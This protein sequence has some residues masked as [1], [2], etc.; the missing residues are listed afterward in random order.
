MNCI[1]WTAVSSLHSNRDEQI[2]IVPHTDPYDSLSRNI[3]ECKFGASEYILNSILG[4]KNQNNQ[5]QTKP[6]GIPKHVLIYSLI[7]KKN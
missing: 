4:K 3:T 5:N 7:K 2:Q 1:L 6:E